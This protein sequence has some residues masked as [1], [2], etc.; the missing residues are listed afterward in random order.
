MAK[1]K[2]GR[3]F[4]RK[5][6]K[7]KGKF[8]TSHRSKV[9]KPSRGLTAS[10]YFFA[11]RVVT[12]VPD[13]KDG[14]MPNGR[15]T[16]NGTLTAT[17]HDGV[18]QLQDLNNYGKY[19]NM[20]EA[21]RINAVKIQFISNATITTSLSGTSASDQIMV[22][23]W[24]DFINNY[25]GGASMPT[26]KELLEMQRCRKRQLITGKPLNI[27]TKV[28]QQNI[29]LLSDSSSYAYTQQKPKWISTTQ[30]ATNHYSLN[31]V[32]ANQD[33][34]VLPNMPVQMVVTY[35]LEFRGQK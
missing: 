3:K 21:Y 24:V 30:P 35:Y 8:S 2:T 32:F 10:R 12:Q 13:I 1:R 23:N 27:Y 20:F 7:N 5:F 14:P 4:S 22:Y 25:S 15:W 34:K 33:G 19:Q 17:M 28:K 9:G 16:N 6:G 31:T 18:F 29:A 11:E 26:V